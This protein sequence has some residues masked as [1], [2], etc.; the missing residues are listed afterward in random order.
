MATQKELVAQWTALGYR[1]AMASA[2]ITPPPP[3]AFRRV[4]HMMQGKWALVAIDDQRLKVSRFEDLNDP[5]ELLAMNRHTQA[6]RRVSKQ[7]RAAFNASQGLLCFGT[8]WSNAV[9]WSHYGDKHKG[10]CL[11]FDVRRSLLQEVR[12]EDRRL[13]LA[14]GDTA[15][16]AALGPELQRQLTCT[17][18]K[19]W[20]YEEE[21]RRFVDLRSAVSGPPHH[22]VPF[23]DD[24]RLA[25]VILGDRC[26][27]NLE[28]V[29]VRL[30]R[31][32]PSAVAF[33]ARL[34][35]RSFRVVLNGYTRPPGSPVK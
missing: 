26:P 2:T 30:E 24:M 10:L 1:K 8:D 20:S 19:A 34:A 12:Y 5:F 31:N 21:L 13:R 33:K 7:F 17:K 28:S 9:M 6:S 18:A 27:E 25:E 16:P 23:D 3:K 22:F 35:Y 14:L 4:Y 15:N 32:C 11:G 29:R